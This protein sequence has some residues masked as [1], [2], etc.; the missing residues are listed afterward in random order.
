MTV[1]AFAAASRLLGLDAH[2][3]GHALAGIDAGEAFAR[4]LF[5]PASGTVAVAGFV[6][7]SNRL[8]EVVRTL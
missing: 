5:D 6:L 1:E 4:G 8:V 3:A 2:A 7:R